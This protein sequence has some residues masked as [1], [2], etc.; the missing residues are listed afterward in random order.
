[1]KQLRAAVNRMI[2]LVVRQR[3][4][5]AFDDELD[6]HL[7]MHIDDN[8][9]AGMSAEDARRR[10]LLKLGGVE[11]TRQS[12][13]E[14]S[15]VPFLEHLWQDLRFAVR[16]LTKT[17]GFT[18]TAII[19]LALGMGAAVAIYAFVD[20]ALVAPLP[21]RDPSRL[22]YVAES[23]PQIP[24][25]N[26]SYLDYLDW[27]RMNT[28]FT[29]LDVFDGRSSALA[30]PGGVEL[31]PG[32]RVSDGFFRTL[33]VAPALGRDFYAGEDLPGKPETLI[34]TH[35]SWHSR[36]GGRRDIVGQVVALSGVPHTIVGI[37]PER[38]QFAPE[39]RAE[40]WMP[41]HPAGGC[42]LRRSCHSLF[43]VAR[44]RDTVNMDRAL[45]EMK[46]IAAQLEREYP[47]SNRGQGATVIA[48]SEAIVGNIRPMLLLLLGGATL[49]LMIACVNVVS[50]LLVRSEGRK[51]EL[52]VRSTLGASNGRLIRQFV[53]EAVVLVVSGGALGLLL[54]SSAVQLLFGLISDDMRSQMPFLDG[55][56]MNAR[57]ATCAAALAIVATA[58]FSLAPAVRV[59]FCEMREGLAEGARGSS[60]NAWRRLGF[61]LVVVELATA[62]VLLVGAG[63]LGK[64][65][66]RLLNVDLGFEPDRLA[67]VQVAAPGP[68]FEKDE[69]AA[70]LGRQVAS[71][72]AALPGVESVGLVDLLPVS[73][74]GNTN[75]IR[76]EGRPYNGEHNEVNSRGVSAGYF[77]TIRA[78]LLR[79]R[80]FTDSDVAGAPGVVIV[81]KTLAAKYF[82]GEDPIG[83]RY[84]D[85]S[86]TPTSMRAIVGIVDDI[87]EGGLD[88]EMWPAEYV[89]FEQDPSTFFSVVARTSQ[90]EAS[91]LPAMSAAIRA[92]DRDL[93][94][95]RDAI[96][97]DRI[98]D[99]PSAYLQ[100]SSAWLVGGF[101]T[102]ALLLGIVGLYGVIAYSVSQRTR[103]I[104]LRLAM[105]AQRRAVYELILGE[106][107]RLI[108]V[109]LMLGLVGS[110]AAARLMRT[111]LFDPTPWDVT[112]LA[113]VAA[114][115]AAAAM[116][117]SY[118]PARRAASVNPIE[119]LR[120]E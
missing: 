85:T 72:I 74:N 13:R 18:A 7:Q 119:A 44:L 28:V 102:L 80:S 84:G 17:P 114:V 90:S 41:L 51:R 87:K 107:G 15:S 112:T 120:V 60:G 117:A 12:Y 97:R 5:E 69:D 99:S 63:L 42:D 86:L 82:P 93:G 115:L 83:K 76:F 3:H 67:T 33:G 77:A 47:D 56:G 89:P 50:L 21:Y 66:Y 53:T 81:N 106:A 6:S 40:F 65:L 61:K 62:M 55:V 8:L 4:E 16:Q 49:L 111:L 52:A 30:T 73:F 100:R 88:S 59:R 46:G 14:R 75:W 11:S 10:A 58:I 116:L 78:T 26:L 103:E 95:R 23:T 35:A 45:A 109:G 70:R 43:G 110:I 38:F 68:R 31:V 48:L 2:G 39:G 57:V 91:V 27:K 34:I 1:M 36:F 118:I 64:S 29:A 113:A 32:A 94:T 92:I 79:G 37:L 22:V 101:A 24:R 104:G 19:T 98:A 20:A 9:R 71:R 25:S 54:A 108:A 105:G 96:M